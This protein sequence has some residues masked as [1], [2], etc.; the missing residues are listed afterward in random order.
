MIARVYALEAK[1]EVL[2][3]ARMPV[4]AVSTI[5]FPVL[6]YAFFGI[7]FGGS[8]PAGAVTMAT[9][10]L[11][12]YGVFGVAGASLFGLGVG[13]AVERGQ[14]WLQLKR[15]TPMPAGA[16]LAAKLAT[17]ALFGAAIVA[18]LSALAVA[19]GGVRMGAAGWIA[20]VATLVV[21]SVPFCAMGLAVGTFAGPNSAAPLVNLIYLPLAFASGL[22]VPVEAL[23]RAVQAVAPWLP[24]YHLAQLALGAVGAGRGEPA[25][26]HVA[27]LAAF[28]ILFL[29]LAAAGYTRGEG[30][31]YG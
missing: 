24:P 3:A 23:P 28:T 17:A 11:A 25:W 12:T 6:F 1:Y 22:W 13:V 19:F 31:T 27:A 7:G 9:Y 4:Y 16:Y 10:L 26:T 30:K 20:L 21:G 2:K 29:G 8:R 5:A 15:A 18:A 14:G